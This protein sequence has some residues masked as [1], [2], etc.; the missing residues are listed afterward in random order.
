MSPVTRVQ[1]ERSQPQHTPQ[2]RETNP[3]VSAS[4]SSS[5]IPAPPS[6]SS[7]SSSTSSSTTTHRPL[8]LS[9]SRSRDPR[10]ASH[11]LQSP[12]R[13][14]SSSSLTNA[15]NNHLISRLP[16]NNN[17]NNIEKSSPPPNAHYTSTPQNDNEPISWS[18]KITGNI[19]PSADIQMISVPTKC[20]RSSVVKEFLSSSERLNGGTKTLRLTAFIK[21]K[22]LERFFHVPAC[23]LDLNHA[24]SNRIGYGKLS[25]F[26]QVNDVVLYIW[27][28]DRPMFL[29]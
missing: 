23:L 4:P 17:N 1:N 13:Q 19:E 18:G 3:I 26:L 7:T 8:S 5:S 21:V 27:M 11:Q 28:V 29:L 24:G 25:R 16:S 22:V 2:R 9:I 14:T 10:L 20:P 12:Q 6:Q 15:L